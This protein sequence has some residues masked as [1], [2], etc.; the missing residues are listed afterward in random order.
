MAVAWSPDYCVCGHGVRAS[1]CS[2][3]GVSTSIPALA[4]TYFFKSAIPGMSRTRAG[5]CLRVR[6]QHACECV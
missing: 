1:T 2:H 3:P 4:W 5:M 6:V